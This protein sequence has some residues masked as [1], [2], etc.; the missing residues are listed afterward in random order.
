VSADVSYDPRT[1]ER[2]GEVRATPPEE[3]EAL[4]ARAAA[5]GRAVATS[6]P[7]RRAG[8]LRAVA[9][10]LEVP[11]TAA[12]L[13]SLADRETA[14]GVARLSGE[15]ARTAAQLRF[16]AEVAEEGSWLGATLDHATGT[17]PALARVRQ[18]LGPVAVFGAS[19]FPFAFGVLGN[20]T[21][22][23]L[24]AGCP[25]VAKAHP[26][27]PLLSVELAR[28]AGAALRDAGAPDGSLGL[29]A[30]FAAGTALVTSP[31]TRALAFTGSQR[32]GLALWRLANEREVVIPVFAEMGTVN[33][34]VLT[35]AGAER[36]EDVAGGFVASFTLGTGQFCTKPGLLLA[37]AGSGAAEAVGRALRAAAPSGWLLTEAI[38]R[39]AVAGVEDLVRAG[40]DVVARVATAAGGWAAPATVLSVE[41][42]ELVHGSRLLEECFGPV[43]LVAEYA[44]EAELRRVLGELQG[45]LAASVICGG[46]ADPDLPAYVAVLAP[47]VGRVTVDDWPT[48]VAW[49]WAQHHGG[50]WPATSAPQ[51]TSVGAAALDRFT[52]PVAYQSVPDAALPPALRAD[53]P[54][55][56]PRR[57]D[58]VMEWPP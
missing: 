24:A 44:D 15:L 7:A 57:V 41:A 54:W 42:V 11:D 23:A 4:L 55:R 12:A 40:G 6:S 28:V 21:A 22:T 14:L 39:D 38:G 50:P 36:L 33:P 53:N 3:V 48:G 13:V 30:G 19:N 26:A 1:G 35:A 31:H 2:H 56:L 52:R 49:T 45:A 43:A 46:P 17:T 47:L 58:G 34:V 5:A 18:P 32:G 20:D 51:A 25:V 10:A 37:P 9:D 16:Y 29:V 8:W 27:H